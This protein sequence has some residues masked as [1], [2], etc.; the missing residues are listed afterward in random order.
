MKI[1]AASVL[2]GLPVVPI[3]AQ[4]PTS[5]GVNFYSLEREIQIGRET[6]AI[7][8]DRVS[9]VR[10]PKMD[11]YVAGLVE[12]LAKYADPRFAYS[13]SI[14]DDRKPLRLPALSMAMPADA[15]LGKATEPVALPGGPILVPLSLLADAPDEASFAFQLA[16]AMAHVA[17]RHS[18]RQ[19]T[20][21]EIERVATIRWNTEPS[22]SDVVFSAGQLGMELGLF[23]FARRFE[24][25][26][27][28]LACDILAES[29]YD[30]AAVVPY[31]EGFAP[32]PAPRHSRIDSVH[33]TTAR[34]TET[35]Q[36]Q[37]EKL[38]ARAYGAGTGEFA[39]M[40]SR[41]AGMR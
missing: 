23:S 20:R 2:L 21:V 40:K 18:T 12:R 13:V 3:Y 27:D 4:E 9:I 22:V 30:P 25:D 28:R 29:G 5:K 14:Y 16:H 6:A 17:L 38:P 7:L 39:E 32:E 41:A 26:A 11:A 19:A 8:V 36:A 15:F 35:I 10:D 37:L 1:V 33:P 24:L 34:R 31:L